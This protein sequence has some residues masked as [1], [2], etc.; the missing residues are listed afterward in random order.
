[1]KLYW[2]HLKLAEMGRRKR[3]DV[4]CK[5]GS[6]RKQGEGGDLNKQAAT[7][8][9]IHNCEKI[10]NTCLQQGLISLH[11]ALYSFNCSNLYFCQVTSMLP[12]CA[13]TPPR[14]P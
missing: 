4:I 1:V 12:S 2:L 13:A 14:I 6:D 8:A 5:S 7:T 11:M 3:D 10:K 9:Q